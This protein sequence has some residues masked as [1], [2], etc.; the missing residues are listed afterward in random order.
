MWYGHVI[1]KRNEGRGREVTSTEDWV[2]W[3]IHCLEEYSRKRTEELILIAPNGNNSNDNTRA[4]R[5]IGI[6]KPI[7]QKWEEKNYMETF[8][9]KVSFVFFQ[10]FFFFLDFLWLPSHAYVLKCKIN[11]HWHNSLK[12]SDWKKRSL[13]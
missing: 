2:E 4:N 13:I 9:G 5:K 7:K 3:T 11:C 8:E 6:M 1:C 12:R 10:W